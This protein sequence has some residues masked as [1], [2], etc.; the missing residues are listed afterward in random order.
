MYYNCAVSDYGAS[1]PLKRHTFQTPGCSSETDRIIFC[2]HSLKE[3]RNILQTI[4][5]RNAN[6][7]EIILRRH[8]LVEHV[9]EG[10]TEVRIEVM[11]IRG[12]RRTQ[13]EERKG[14]QRK[15]KERKEKKIAK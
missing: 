7:I 9:N 14:K 5:R 13:L 12:K 8:C 1:A 11:G 15:G 4:K 3:K 6:W 10:K 2:S